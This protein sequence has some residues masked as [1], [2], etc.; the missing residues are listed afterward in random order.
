MGNL[1]I[2]IGRWWQRQWHSGKTTMVRDR[3]V[4]DLL[5]SIICED[6][7]LQRHMWRNG[8]TRDILRRL[9]RECLWLRVHYSMENPIKEPIL[10]QLIQ[11]LRINVKTQ[12]G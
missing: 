2:G 3:M 1:D 6:F 12:N 11:L 10:E 4:D 5:P 7:L 8:N 9:E